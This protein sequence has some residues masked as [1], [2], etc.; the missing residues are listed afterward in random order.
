MGIESEV[1]GDALPVAERYAKFLAEA[2]VERGL[3]GP[4]EV[5]RL[6]ER[7]LINCAV[8]AEVIPERARVVDIGS[9]AGL[10]GIVLAIV[11]PDLSI[12]LLEPLLRRTTFLNECVE[13]LGLTNVVVRRARAEEVASEFSM[14]V[15]T[16]RAVAPLERL[17]R[18]A[19]PLLRPGGELLALK[20][21]RAAVELEEAQPVLKRF[22]VRTT[23]LLQVGRG[24][25]DPPT[26]LVRV[27]AEHAPRRA[28]GSRKKRSS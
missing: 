19:L 10:P 8:V 15:A 13:M 27:V 23:E 9:G 25:V 4:R 22:G 3:I 7:H 21:E 26:T 2:G 12:T 17:A 28:K 18:W 1:F 6:W 16:A 20:G 11:R 24:K 5:D 14:D